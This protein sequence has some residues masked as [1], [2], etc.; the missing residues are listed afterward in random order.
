[1]KSLTKWN[2]F[3]SV[4]GTRS[5]ERFPHPRAL[6]LF[7]ACMIFHAGWRS[8]NKRPEKGI[9]FGASLYALVD[10]RRQLLTDAV[11]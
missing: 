4:I 3:S 11:N 6:R 2:G 10:T 8:G 5:I 7:Y 9:P 1:M